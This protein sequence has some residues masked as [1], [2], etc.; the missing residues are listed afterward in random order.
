MYV[1]FSFLPKIIP[2]LSHSLQCTVCNNCC[3]NIS[4][5]KIRKWQKR[6]WTW[7]QSYLVFPSCDDSRDSYRST[8]VHPP[9][10]HT[11]SF[12]WIYSVF[13]RG[14]DYNSN[15]TSSVCVCLRMC[16][17]GAGLLSSSCCYQLYFG[18]IWLTV[19][20]FLKRYLWQED[21]HILNRTSC[22]WLK[23]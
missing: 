20:V 1:S 19:K 16:V 6:K 23:V 17:G 14:G 10:H 13:I 18:R 21:C 22:I 12:C 5:A 3:H 15:T 9:H 2:H 8:N 11:P 4:T 7:I